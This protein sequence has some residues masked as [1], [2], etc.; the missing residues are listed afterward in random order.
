MLSQFQLFVKSKVY[1]EAILF[2]CDFKHVKDC[3]FMFKLFK[4]YH[5]KSKYINKLIINMRLGGASNQSFSIVLAQN[6]EIQKARKNN[7]L[8]APFYLMP[9]ETLKRLTQF[10]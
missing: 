9:L 4:K 6:K 1:N 8:K 5:F 7:G 2:N 3:E 10:V